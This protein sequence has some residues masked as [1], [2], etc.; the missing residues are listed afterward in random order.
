MCQAVIKNTKLV[1]AKKIKLRNG[2]TKNFTKDNI[3]N[4]LKKK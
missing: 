2:V 4:S 3:K 1:L